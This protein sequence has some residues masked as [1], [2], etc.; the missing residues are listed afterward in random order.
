M[1]KKG[2]VLR[3]RRLTIS[4]RKRA[5]SYYTEAEHQDIATAAAAEGVSLSSFIAAATLKEARK[6]R[7]K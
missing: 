5:T 3:R 1:P 6:K 4:V 2:R 7:P